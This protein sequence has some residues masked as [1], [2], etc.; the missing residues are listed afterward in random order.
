MSQDLTN[1]LSNLTDEL[2][3]H[4]RTYDGAVY[5]GGDSETSSDVGGDD[6]SVEAHQETDL[7]L[8]DQTECQD[9]HH[10]MLDDPGDLECVDDPVVEAHDDMT[11]DGNDD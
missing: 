11:D 6:S 9:D 4:R 1:A 2:S 7:D 5:Y 3:R 10:D 8:P